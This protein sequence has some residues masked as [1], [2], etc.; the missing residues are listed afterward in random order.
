MMEGEQ[1]AMANGNGKPW[2]L[3][4]L[5][6][7]F[8]LGRLRIPMLDGSE[9]IVEIKGRHVR[10]LRVV[11]EAYDAE[12]GWDPL[13]RGLRTAK[14]IAAQYYLRHEIAGDLS[15]DAVHGYF[16]QVNGLIRK[17]AG[18]KGDDLIL[19]VGVRY[20]GF[21]LVRELRIIPYR[22]VAVAA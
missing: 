13:D 16:S 12:A 18:R 9:L 5:A 21:H 22:K 19:F 11:A 20:R 14:E 10:V 17:K 6:E 1:A 4:I 7:D 8:A 15:D 2:T 3:E